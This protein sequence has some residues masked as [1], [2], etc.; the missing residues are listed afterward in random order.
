MKCQ[1]N[2]C[3]NEATHAICCLREIRAF[4]CRK[5][6]LELCETNVLMK[7]EKVHQWTDMK[8]LDSI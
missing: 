4:L 2:G 5:H 3:K 1:L 6:A 7:I 8:R